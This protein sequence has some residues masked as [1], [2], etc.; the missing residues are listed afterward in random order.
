MPM[1][2]V[3]LLSALLTTPALAAGRPVTLQDL[4]AF[5]ALETP[6]VA[7]NGKVMAFSAQPDRGDPVGVVRLTDGSKKLTVER[8][9][10]PTLTPDGRYVAFWQQPTLLAQ[11]E[12]KQQ[13]KKD[14]PQKGLV[15]IDSQTGAKQLFADVSRFA[16]ADKGGKLAVEMAEK[17]ATK[18]DDDKKAKAVKQ[19]WLVDLTSGK[20]QNLGAVG[21]FAFKPA[22]DVLAYA[23]D[24]K[25]DSAAGEVHLLAAKDQL[26][27]SRSGQLYR[28]LTFSKDGKQFAALRGPKKEDDKT[29]AYQVLV[30]QGSRLQ[31]LVTPQ[32]NFYVSAPNELRF[33]EDGR[34]LFVGRKPVVKPDTRTTPDVHSQ[35]DLT[36]IDKIVASRTL[37]VWQGDD[38]RIKP[39]EKLTY[40]ERQ[41]HL[42]LGVFHLNN[43]RFVQ[44]ADRSMPD[45]TVG[46]Q[47]GFLLGASDI[48][49]LKAVTWNGFYSDYYAVNP[50]TGE[51]TLIAKHLSQQ[52]SLSPQGHY[53]VFFQGGDVKIADIRRHKVLN[54]TKGLPI[55]FG[56]EDNDYPAPAPGYGFGPWYK[57]GSAVLVYD[58]FDVWQMGSNGKATQLTHKRAD[59]LE[60]RVVTPDADQPYVAKGDKLLLTG[61]SDKDKYTGFFRLTLGESGVSPLLVSPNTYQFVAKAKNSDTWLFSKEAF[62]EFPDLWVAKSDFS[63]PRKLTDVNPVTK[64]FAWGKPELVHWHNMDGTPLDGVLIKPAGY[65][66]GKRYP[67]LVYYYRFMTDRL[68]R[69]NE[70]KINHRPNFAYYTSHGYAM[71]LPD[72]RFDVGTPGKSSVSA[73][74]P[75]VQKLIDMGI[76]DPKAIGLHGHSWSGYQT[77]Y[78]VTQTNIFA[79]AVAGAPVTNMTS[80]YSGIRLGSGL[81]RQF[82]YETGQSRIGQ[83]LFEAPELYIENSPVFYADRIHTPLVIEFG[84]KDDAVPWQQ[85]IELYSAMRRLDK[86]VVMLQYEGEPHHLKQYGNK[87]DYTIKMKAFFDHFLK[88]AP[89]PAW[90]SK[91][92][93][94]RPAPKAKEQEKAPA[95]V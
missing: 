22:S 14:K 18:A 47:S 88:G 1:F 59:Q 63:A 77:A 95:K 74:V 55:G 94:Y 49:Y 34:R 25:D 19:L 43:G 80:A 30:L 16:L 86:P 79:A 13:K 50:S 78:V 42:Y 54:L 38:P 45:V 91:G 33:S 68:Y 8:G 48:P 39:E 70:F 67:V 65:Q 32:D 85:G 24:P 29:R 10:E 69:F 66:P 71:F 83:S 84:D 41:K 23:L 64:E 21:D 53:A 17:S 87:L 12:A 72:I 81:S 36:N 9:T 82:Q 6:T 35:A 5:K 26:L 52:P 44:L 27:Q 4:M 37:E 61:Y 3:L 73:L 76:A 60:L 93:P 40:K 51:R 28:D 90:W 92:Q 20:R 11:I 58:K 56:N 31:A 89:A 15:V 2:R 46:E 62:S 57:D 7:E 75:G